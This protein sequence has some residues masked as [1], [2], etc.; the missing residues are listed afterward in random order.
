MKIILVRHG[1][2][3]ENK[4][5]IMQGH[6]PGTLSKEGKMQAEKAGARLKDEKFD[7]IY[8]SDLARAADTAEEIAKHHTGKKVILTKDIREIDHGSF[9][10]KFWKDVE[11]LPRPDD[12]ETNEQIVIRAKKFIDKIYEKHKNNTV[13][14][15]GHNKI[16]KAI[17]SAITGENISNMEHF[18]NT[19]ISIFEIKQDRQHHIHLLNCDKHLHE[20]NY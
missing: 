14:L 10:G 16:N 7:I 11:N 9:S 12:A 18:K 17:I 1:E 2:T 20:Q 6:M 19:S 4:K 15:V 13:L 5:R 8:S 3:E